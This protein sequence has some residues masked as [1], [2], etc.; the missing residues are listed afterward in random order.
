MSEPFE[1]FNLDTMS[2]VFP[3]VRTRV[4]QRVRLAPLDVPLSVDAQRQLPVRWARILH[5]ENPSSCV[6]ELE[7]RRNTEAGDSHRDR[8]IPLLRIAN[9]EPEHFALPFQ[10]A[11]AATGWRLVTCG[12]CAH[13]RPLHAHTEDGIPVGRCVWQ[14]P[15]QQN[16]FS[17]SFVIQLTAQSMLALDCIHWQPETTLEAKA[18]EPLQSETIAPI[19][20]RAEQESDERWTWLGRLRRRLRRAPKLT[21]QST[22][23]PWEERILERS[24]VGAGTE[25]CFACQGKIANLG[26]LTAAT[27]EGDKQTFSVWRCRTCYTYYLNDWIDRWERTE[28]LETEERFYRLAP[29][30]ALEALTVIDNVAGAEHPALRHERG[31][32]RNWMLTLIAGRPPLSHQIRQGR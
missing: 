20:K 1:R 15:I 24:G 5:Y 17:S 11:L 21:G 12:A 18:A 9:P 10:E 7:A 14:S 31:A 4:Y 16:S 27:P 32:Q 25:P 2:G 19:R 26:A 22:E 8:P 6:V 3:G 23:R 28:S 30:E 13:W 29:A